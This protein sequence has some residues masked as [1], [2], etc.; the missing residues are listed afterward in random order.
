MN[1][2]GIGGLNEAFWHRVLD[3]IEELSGTGPVILFGSRAKGTYREGSD[4]DL[5]LGN[6]SLT[7]LQAQHIKEEL[8]ER[9]FPYSFDVISLGCLTD[10]AVGEH[11][12]RVGITLTGR[13]E[14]V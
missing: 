12:A 11:I 5:A 6:L 4:I 8:E 9:F 2:Q 10:Q 3:F 14:A 13:K 7:E 1:P